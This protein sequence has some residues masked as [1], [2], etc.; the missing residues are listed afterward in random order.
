M[1]RLEMIARDLRAAAEHLSTAPPGDYSV[2]YRIGAAERRIQSALVEVERLQ[3]EASVVSL[4][5]NLA[6]CEEADKLGVERSKALR[7]VARASRRKSA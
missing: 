5:G 7:I 2:H 3:A 4:A 1:D 6:A